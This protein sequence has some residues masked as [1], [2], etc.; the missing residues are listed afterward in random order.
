M[1]NEITIK[2][3][4]DINDAQ[5]QEYYAGLKKENINCHFLEFAINNN[6]K[7]LSEPVVF[8][9][10]EFSDYQVDDISFIIEEGKIVGHMY[11]FLQKKPPVIPLSLGDGNHLDLKRVKELSSRI[12]FTKLEYFFEYDIDI[13]NL[14]VK[15]LSNRIHGNLE[16]KGNIEIENK[17]H[18]KK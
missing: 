15:Y 8:D 10:K 6:S 14:I 3:G 4:I 9:E 7:V 18:I 1:T 5:F 2:S 12:I 16:Y 13:K 11:Y 17:I